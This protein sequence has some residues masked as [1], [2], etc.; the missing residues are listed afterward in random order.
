[1]PPYISCEQL[2]VDWT[3]TTHTVL[4][5]YLQSQEFTSD[6][7]TTKPSA[8]DP[9]AKH[10]GQRGDLEAQISEFRND[11]GSLGYTLTTVYPIEP[12]FEPPIL[13]CIT[14]NPMISVVASCDMLCPR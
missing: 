1:M 12:I 13:F 14:N 11:Q 10:R 6:L 5:A 8:H 9:G 2:P 3:A 4:L 7:A